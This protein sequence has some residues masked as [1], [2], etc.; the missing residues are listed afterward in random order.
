[1]KLIES[2]DVLRED[3]LHLLRN[4]TAHLYI[5][6]AADALPILGV[7]VRLQSKSFHAL[8]EFVRVN[9]YYITLDATI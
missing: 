4:N 5:T 6:D 1:V 2:V 8:Q 9:V 7:L 3:L